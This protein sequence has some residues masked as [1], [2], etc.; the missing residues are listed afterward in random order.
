MCEADLSCLEAGDRSS[1]LSLRCQFRIRL[2][3][4]AILRQ[5]LCRRQCQKRDVVRCLESLNFVSWPS[6]SNAKE[7][8]WAPLSYFSN[9]RCRREFEN[10]CM[11][12]AIE[13][14]RSL[15]PKLPVESCWVLVRCMSLPDS[16]SGCSRLCDV[17]PESLRH[18]LEN[19]QSMIKDK[20]ELDNMH[21]LLLR[22]GTQY[23]RE[24]VQSE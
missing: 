19:T 15:F 1:I 3:F 5:R 7:R 2:M 23:S 9:K 14:P 21:S 10:W 12:C 18:H 22:I 24:I 13:L 20:A 17:A 8:N 16:L 6:W 4:L 11:N